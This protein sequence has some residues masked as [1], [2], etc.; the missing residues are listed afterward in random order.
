M[1]RYGT[2]DPD[3]PWPADARVS[4]KLDGIYARA[5]AH[6]LYTKTGRKIANRQDLEEALKPFFAQKP[7]A[8]LE[9]E[10]YRHGQPFERNLSDYQKGKPLPYHLFP[11][12]DSPGRLKGVRRV[13]DAPAA[14]KDA[15]EAH[16]QEAIKGGYEG[17][18]IHL[19]SGMRIKRKPSEDSEYTVRAVHPT[20]VGRSA[21]VADERGQVRVKLP[22]HLHG[23]T[24]GQRVTVIYQG[25]TQKG[26]PRNAQ[27]KAIRDGY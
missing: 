25:R 4:P 17:Q 9:G 26:V 23:A 21:T 19:P 13:K 10:L 12:Q 14:T 11:G 15:A 3:K 8:K 5:Q 2:Y 18:V 6:G 24:P 27:V 1:S 22:P 16:Y 20:K 7:N